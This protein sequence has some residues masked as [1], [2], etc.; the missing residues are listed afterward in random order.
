MLDVIG[1]DRDDFEE[2]LE[3]FEESTPQTLQK[4]TEAAQSADLDALR[5]ASHSLKSNGRDF[6]AAALAAA[7]E[8]LEQ[9]CREGSVDDPQARVTE[10]SEELQ[11]AR[12]ALA[13]VE[14]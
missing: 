12:A 6:G 7:C 8:A 14:L 2:L 5:I 3:E 10:I 11:R 1:G 13:G 9:A 4:M